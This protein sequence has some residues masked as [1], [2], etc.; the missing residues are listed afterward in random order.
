MA[1]SSLSIN[2]LSTPPVQSCHYTFLC[3]TLSLSAFLS[4]RVF[5]KIWF[6]GG[7]EHLNFG[8]SL[9]SGR[10]AFSF[11][12]LYFWN[13]IVILLMK[14]L[15]YL[16]LLAQEKIKP[17]K[18]TRITTPT[19]EI[20]HCAE[21]Y[22]EQCASQSQVRQDGIKIESGSGIKEILLFSPPIWVW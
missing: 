4:W 13:K 8:C 17:N 16:L 20:R 21:K 19:A 6:L 14:G 1:C 5:R 7:T 2:Y 22:M 15:T 12:P 18:G 9:L 10:M 11:S 3:M